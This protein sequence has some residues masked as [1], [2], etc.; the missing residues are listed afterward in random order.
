ME[1]RSG[2]RQAL[3]DAY[4]LTQPQPRLLGRADAAIP[5]FELLL[6]LKG[7]RDAGAQNE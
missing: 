7:E 4:G 2:S 3:L 6:G 1:A 5:R